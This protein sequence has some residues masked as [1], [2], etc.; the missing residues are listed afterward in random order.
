MT[1]IYVLDSF[2]LL[3]V[4]GGE[5]GGKQ[6][7]QLLQQAQEGVVRALMSWVNLGEVGYMVER[8]WGRE[9][10]F[11]VLGTLEMTALELVPVERGLAL[12]AAHIKAS[13]PVAYADAFAAALAM[14]T[15]A[16]LL[17]GDPEFRLLED[18]LPITWLSQSK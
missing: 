18:V 4:L 13:H 2:A 6:V 5:P 10:F 15:S 7:T 9:R 14:E 11:H 8:R 1:E 16:T 17:T 12:A 3:A